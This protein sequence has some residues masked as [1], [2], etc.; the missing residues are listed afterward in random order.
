MRLYPHD[1]FSA[2]PNTKVWDPVAVFEIINPDKGTFTCVGHAP[3]KGRRCR[4]DINQQNRQEVYSLLD[5][6][7]VLSPSNP[8]VSLLL[9]KITFK[10]LCVRYHRDQADHVA[11]IWT[12]RLAMLS[13]PPGRIRNGRTTGGSSSPFEGKPRQPTYY[14]QS[15][16]HSEDQNQYARFERNY[17]QRTWQHQERQYKQE[18]D[19]TEQESWDDDEVWQKM[20]EKAWQRREEQREREAENRKRKNEERERKAKVQREQERARQEERRTRERADR[21]R[22]ATERA[23]REKREWQQAWHSYVTKWAAFRAL[24]EDKKPKTPLQARQLIPWPNKSGRFDDSTKLAVM[25]FYRKACPDAD[26]PDKMAKTMRSESLKWHS[27]KSKLL[28]HGCEP[29]VDDKEIL[30]I[31]CLAVIELKE[32]ADAAKAR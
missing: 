11:Q 7:S 15:F 8:E 18:E 17:K 20:R 29:G 12:Q 3:S 21:E 1:S 14:Q 2:A 10:S 19:T 13:H 32:Q 9:G 24:S 5:R 26:T 22:E 4:W 16:Y 30:K 27:D 28:Y 23:M 31:I 6:I 25:D